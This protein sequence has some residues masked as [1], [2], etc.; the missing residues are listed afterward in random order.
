MI[1]PL[2]AFFFGIGSVLG[3]VLGFWWGK[4]LADEN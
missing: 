2:Y 4:G 3:C 1:D